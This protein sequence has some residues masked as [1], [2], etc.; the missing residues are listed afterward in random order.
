MLLRHRQS[1][2][3]V[4]P[5]PRDPD[6]SAS[7]DSWASVAERLLQTAYPELELRMETLPFEYV[8]AKPEESAWL[9]A[10][11]RLR[12]DWLALPPLFPEQLGTCSVDGRTP[13]PESFKADMIRVLAEARAYA[14]RV[15]LFLPYGIDEESA[16]RLLPFAD[17]AYSAAWETGC[18]PVD[19]QTAIDALLRQHAHPAYKTD[20]ASP[21]ARDARVQ[22][23]LASAFLRRMGF[24]W[25]RGL[26]FAAT[27]ERQPNVL[28]RSC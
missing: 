20:D 15:T 25:T 8:A 10:A 18:Q 12:P 17:A 22:L 28:P 7:A 3:F 6:A 16:T 13:S 19:V 9:E 2:L 21:D 27:G 26:G 23:A 14:G 11:R 24:R 4:A 5:V 1:L